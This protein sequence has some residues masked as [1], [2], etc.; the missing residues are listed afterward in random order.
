[1]KLKVESE[2]CRRCPPF[3][4]PGPPSGTA[5]GRTPAKH[6]QGRGGFSCGESCVR[7]L[8]VAFFYSLLSSRSRHTRVYYQ[9]VLYIQ[10]QYPVLRAKE[11]RGATRR[12]PRRFTR[13]ASLTAPGRAPVGAFRMLPFGAPVRKNVFPRQKTP[14]RVRAGARRGENR[15]SLSSC[16]C[17]CTLF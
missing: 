5:P 7:R 1:M 8:L 17:V 2:R 3:S 14:T 16:V 4:S 13:Y 12:P 6:H 9:A 10:R 11:L 15:S